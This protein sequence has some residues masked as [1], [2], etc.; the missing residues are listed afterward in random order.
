MMILDVSLL[1]S[2]SIHWV[3]LSVSPNN[4]NERGIYMLEIIRFFVRGVL[5]LSTTIGL[6][7]MVGCTLF[8]M[9]CVIHGDVKI[10][11]TRSK[12]EKENE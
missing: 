9:A 7:F 10:N 1:K 8:I 6:V 12:A 2:R 3:G 11:I 5:I 4:K